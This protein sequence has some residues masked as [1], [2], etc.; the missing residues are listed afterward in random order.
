MRSAVVRSAN[1]DVAQRSTGSGK[2]TIAKLIQRLYI[3]IGPRA[4][5][6]IDLSMVDPAWLRRQL[7]V[8]CRRAS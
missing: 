6:C 5:R 3:P 4:G 2:S 8:G 7:G 1:Q